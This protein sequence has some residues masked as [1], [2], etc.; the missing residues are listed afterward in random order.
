MATAVSFRQYLKSLSLSSYFLR[1][2]VLQDESKLFAINSFCKNVH[3]IQMNYNMLSWRRAKF[4]ANQT[5]IYDYMALGFCSARPR[6]KISHFTSQA[7]LSW[8]KLSFQNYMNWEMLSWVSFSEF[9]Q[10][11]QL[12][13]VA[14]IDTELQLI[15]HPIFHMCQSV[16]FDVCGTIMWL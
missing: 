8:K 11:G 13:V 2:V 14:S 7:S 4:V 12:I 6:F 15:F 1:C 9:N 16:M 10:L 3:P 5:T